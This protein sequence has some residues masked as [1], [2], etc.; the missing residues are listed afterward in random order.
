MVWP[1]VTG[2]VEDVNFSVHNKGNLREVRV[3]N[4]MLGMTGR[5]DGPDKYSEWQILYSLATGQRPWG[6]S[7]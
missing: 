6:V 4:G 7:C 3:G 2:A 1:Q 5:G